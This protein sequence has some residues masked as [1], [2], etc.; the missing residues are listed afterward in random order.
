MKDQPVQR[1]G[2]FQRGVC[3]W[4]RRRQNP[5]QIQASDPEL[6]SPRHQCLGKN[7]ALAA[8]SEV[9]PGIATGLRRSALR[10]ASATSAI[11][12]F[13]SWCRTRTQMP[14]VSA[15]F[16]PA[17][18]TSPPVPPCADPRFSE[19]TE[20]QYRCRIQLQRHG[21]LVPASVHVVGVKGCFRPTTRTAMPSM[22]SRTAGVFSFTSGSSVNPQDPRIFVAPTGRQSTMYAT[23]SMRAMCGN[24]R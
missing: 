18:C 4:V 1:C 6:L 19:V 2:R 22:K 13:T 20:Y 7:D 3:R 16:L 23:P 11:T 15:R 10:S 21:R 14:L 9:E 17:L 5:A 8:I 12:A 24:S